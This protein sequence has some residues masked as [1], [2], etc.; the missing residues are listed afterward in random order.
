MYNKTKAPNFHQK[1]VLSHPSVPRQPR[2]HHIRWW[3]FCCSKSK[4][5]TRRRETERDEKRGKGREREEKRGSKKI[6][7]C[8]MFDSCCATRC[9]VVRNN[10]S[11]F[12]INLV[13]TKE[14]KKEEGRGWEESG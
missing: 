12:C 11:S 13:L 8:D 6:P 14:Y 4:K 1:R 2:S 7:V 5:E 9:L 3:S 10:H